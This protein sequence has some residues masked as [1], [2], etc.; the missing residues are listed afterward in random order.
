MSTLEAAVNFNG[1]T[2]SITNSFNV[3]SI[4]SV[5]SAYQLNFTVPISNVNYI[6]LCGGGNGAIDALS[7]FAQGPITNNPSQTSFLMWSGTSGTNQGL[8]YTYCVIYTP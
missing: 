6:A 4:T 1:S 8:A 3:T 7:W 2:N 5:G